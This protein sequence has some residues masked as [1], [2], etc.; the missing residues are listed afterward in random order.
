MAI[1][2]NSTER[3]KHELKQILWLAPSET[4]YSAIEIFVA[5]AV[6]K[7]DRRKTRG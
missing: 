7:S 5:A 3:P 6:K 4:G 1:S 2:T